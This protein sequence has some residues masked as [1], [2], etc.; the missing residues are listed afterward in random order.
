[1]VVGASLDVVPLTAIEAKAYG[2]CGQTLSPTALSVI[3]AKNADPVASHD[4]AFVVLS[5]E[6]DEVMYIHI[7]VVSLVVGKEYQ[8]LALFRHHRIPIYL[9]RQE[10]AN[11]LVEGGGTGVSAPCFTKNAV[12]ILSS[13]RCVLAP[14]SSDVIM[15]LLRVC[16][17]CLLVLY[18]FNCH[19]T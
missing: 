7:H 6:V 10:V 2:V 9:L 3:R 8:Q 16:Y 4:G 11:I 5:E 12:D 14:V 18:C 15:I 13:K 1:M 19:H 17:L